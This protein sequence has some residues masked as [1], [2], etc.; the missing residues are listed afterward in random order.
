MPPMPTEW[1]LRPVSSA[2]RVGEQSAVVWKRLYLRPSRR[3]P[4]GRRRVARAAEGARR[5]E[6]DVVEQDDEHVR[7]AGRRAQSLDR[8]EAGVR[9][10]GVVRRQ[11]DVRLIGDRQDRSTDHLA[12]SSPPRRVSVDR[13][14]WRRLQIWHVTLAGLDVVS[15]PHPA[16]MRLRRAAR[17]TGWRRERSRCRV[18]GEN[19]DGSGLQ[20]PGS[21]SRAG[22][23]GVGHEPGLE[24]G[25]R[26]TVGVVAGEQVADDLACA[27]DLSAVRRRTWTDQTIASLGCDGLGCRVAL[28]LVVRRCQT[29][30]RL[31][32]RAELPW[33]LRSLACREYAAWWKPRTIL[34]PTPHGRSSWGPRSRNAWKGH[35]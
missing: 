22:L 27:G 14:W 7:R 19:V 20:N 2:A 31:L 16:A 11:A 21:A 18:P 6:A 25:R 33:P 1:W 26:R 23:C 3:Q 4:L 10:L 15:E 29:Q 12:H 32:R 28:A 8:R 5:G 24:R 9:I 34:A 13:R 30:R 17:R 35:S